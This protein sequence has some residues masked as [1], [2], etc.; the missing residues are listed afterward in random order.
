MRP[1]S[2]TCSRRTRNAEMSQ[3]DS[4]SHET[5]ANFPALR[6]FLRGYMHQ[7]MQ[8]E[9]GSAENAAK[10]FWRDADAE[11][12]R[13]TAQEWNRLTAQFKDRPLPELNRTL[14]GDLGSAQQLETGDIQKISAVLNG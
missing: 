4:R 3:H 12:R 10:Q 2:I 7:D 14:T 13:A 9:Y 11:Q 5:H 6:E 1:A 8:E